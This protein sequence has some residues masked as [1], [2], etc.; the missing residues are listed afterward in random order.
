MPC[1]ACLYPRKLRVF[2][3][4]SIFAIAVTFIVYS[5][6]GIYGYLTFGTNVRP[7]ILVRYAFNILTYRPPVRTI[8]VFLIGWPASC[9][10]R[11]LHVRLESI[12]I[13]SHRRI[14][15]Q[16]KYFLLKLLTSMPWDLITSFWFF[17]RAA[18]ESLWVD[19]KNLDSLE[20][21]IGERRRRI[22]CGTLWFVSS[23]LIGIF[24]PSIQSVIG[25]L[26][27]LAATF[28]FIYPGK[29]LKLFNGR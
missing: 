14:L 11:L 1:Y 20:I 2:T 7:D 9:G 10:P 29:G 22:V 24:V 28:V 27:S 5:L 8:S 23:L 16:V 18:L 4:S 26:G 21:I 19:W 17:F 25:I 6:V 15:R 12:F 3:G 13:I